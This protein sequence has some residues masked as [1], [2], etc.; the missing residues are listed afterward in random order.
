[1]LPA[2][3]GLGTPWQLSP[4]GALRCPGGLASSRVGAARAQERH[5]LSESLGLEAVQLW[6]S[7]L[8]S[9]LPRS[10]P[11]PSVPSPVS[12]LQGW[13]EPGRSD[14]IPGQPLCLALLSPAPAQGRDAPRRSC[15][16]VLPQAELPTARM[17]QCLVLLA[18]GQ[19]GGGRWKLRS[20][21][22]W[23]GLQ[24]SQPQ[25]ELSLCL[26]Q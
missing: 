26:L 18:C 1:M 23:R 10:R 22:A 8:P 25:M 20:G 3:H 12:R 21:G 4:H 17:W 15:L 2:A 11:W 5:L 7:S 13:D 16:Q 19:R 6:E 9:Q 24:L 14:H